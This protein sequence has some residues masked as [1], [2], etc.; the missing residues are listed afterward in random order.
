AEPQGFTVSR[1]AEGLDHPRMIYVM[2]DGAVMVAESS[3]QNESGGGAEGAIR[4]WIQDYAGAIAAS[5]NRVVRL[6]DA[7]GDGRAEA[8]SDFAQGLNQP[9]GMLLI[10]NWFYVA[11]TDALVKFATTP[12][13]P[14]VEGA[15][16][17]VMQLPRYANDNGHWTRNLVANADG[18]KIYI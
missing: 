9:F 6:V 3:S 2:P 11:N 13:A 15:P 17:V 7:D 14:H 12:G 18:S 5:P 1:F 4:N 8:R 16:T 10:G